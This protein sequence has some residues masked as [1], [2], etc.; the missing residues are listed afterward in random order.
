[1]PGSPELRAMSRSRHSCWRTSP[2]MTRDGRIR[3]A[4]FTSA[5]RVISPVPSRLGCRV[6]RATT[7][8]S[9]TWSS[10][11]SSQVMTRSRTGMDALRQLSIVVLPACVAPATRMFNPATTAASRNRPAT[12]GSV[13][14]S[15]RS[16]T[17]RA[18]T[19]NLR[20]FNAQCSR[21]ASGIAT[22]SRLPSGSVASTNGCDRSMRRPVG[23][24]IR[25]TR[26][27]TRSAVSTVVVSS[28]RPPRAMKTLVGSL[29]QISST[30]GSS[31]YCCNGPSPARVSNSRRATTSA[32]PS[33]G[34]RA[35]SIRAR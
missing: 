7:S 2:T 31:R 26:S 25:S 3:S 33:G 13:P 9:G 22:C 19:T 20:M 23:F 28:L 6:C 8:G 14:S 35:V 32:S 5:R 4:S 11:T 1:M 12:A 10:K 29:T 24:S 21:V 34:S 17:W 18:R 27:R 30:D 16:S 15:T